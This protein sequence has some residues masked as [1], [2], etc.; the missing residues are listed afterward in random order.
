MPNPVL[1]EL[2]ASIV[3]AHLENNNVPIRDLPGMISG[4]Y[5]ALA[6]IGQPAAKPEV[7]PE[8]AVS[9][10]SSVKPASIACLDCGKKQRALKRHIGSAHGLTPDA[11]RARWGLPAN[12]PMVAPEYSARRSAM[13][14]ATG[15]GRK[16]GPVAAQQAKA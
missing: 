1:I 6:D 10:R 15:L 13:A 14:K 7:R 3:A 5:G 9:V 11:Y 8:P 12:Y 4:V 2:T 16:P